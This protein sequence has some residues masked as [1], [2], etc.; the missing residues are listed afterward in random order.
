MFTW[1]EYVDAANPLFT[2]GPK[3]MGKVGGGLH[4]LQ[5]SDH[6]TNGDG[7]HQGSSNSTERCAFTLISLCYP[8]CC[9]IA[10]NCITLPQFNWQWVGT[11]LFSCTLTLDLWT[12]CK[13][14]KRW[15]TENLCDYKILLAQS[16]I[17]EDL[18]NT[19]SCQGLSPFPHWYAF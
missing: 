5:V 12:S 3:F 17:Q 6:L 13:F 19:C 15:S 11:S 1:E 18:W 16:R 14:D 9:Q 10:G 2:H 8:T 7:C 4:R